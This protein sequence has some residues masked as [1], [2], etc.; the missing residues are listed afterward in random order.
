LTEIQSLLSA[1]DVVDQLAASLFARPRYVIDAPNA[2]EE[3]IRGGWFHNGD[4]VRTRNRHR[5]R[6]SDIT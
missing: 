1:G 6:V 5:G 2:P 4:M 3:A